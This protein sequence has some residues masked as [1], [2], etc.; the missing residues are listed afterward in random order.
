MGASIILQP[1]FI[2]SH[3]FPG[4]RD[5][6][7]RMCSM[8]DAIPHPAT[9]CTLLFSD[10]ARPRLSAVRLC[11]QILKTRLNWPGL[12]IFIPMYGGLALLLGFQTR[13][14]AQWTLSLTW[15]CCNGKRYKF[16]YIHSLRYIN[17]AISTSLSP[18]HNT[19]CSLPRSVKNQSCPV[20][21]WP[22]WP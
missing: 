7:R 19:L 4:Y 5:C 17:P 3:S 15:L 12:N 8:F 22:F 20:S 18:F 13:A 21:S 6:L 14:T 10:C 2:H 9:P 11:K 16:R 1:S